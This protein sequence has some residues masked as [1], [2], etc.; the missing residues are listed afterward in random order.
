MQILLNILKIQVY[1]FILQ[2]YY[3]H[4]ERDVLPT[5]LEVD[6]SNKG[7]I[8]EQVFYNRKSL[9]EITELRYGDIK[10][11][12]LPLTLIIKYIYLFQCC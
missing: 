3:R 10:K 1:L 6:E 11:K 4:S 2:T 7:T 9:K 8:E 12:G 5:M